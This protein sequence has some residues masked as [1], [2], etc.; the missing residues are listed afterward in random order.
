MPTMWVRADGELELREVPR[1]E[2]TADRVLVRTLVSAV[3]GSDLHRFRGALSYGRDTDVFGHE[4]VVEVIAGG[5]GTLVPGQRMLHLPFPEEGK[6]FA[7]Y[8]LA[9]EGNLIPLPAGLP[10]GDAVLAQQLGTVLHA[11][12]QFWP[13]PT[14]PRSAFIAGAGPAGLLFVQVLRMLGC[15]QIAVSEPHPPRLA[16]AQR[17][18]AVTPESVP[19]ANLSIDAVGELPARRDCF[20]HTRRA[21]TLGAFGLPDREPGELGI[22]LLEL[23]GRELRLV[24]AQGA[25]SEPGLGSFHRAIDLLHRRAIDTNCLISHRI[26]LPE[27]PQACLQAAGPS[28]DIVKVLVVFS[29]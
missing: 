4:S 9:R 18:G 21:G 5:S 17:L 19:S 2:P 11:L 8:Q 27:L 13:W 14:P 20:A 3:C 12:D 10:D 7:D 26:S 15:A 22:S 6:V 23:L 29:S 28:G 1:P 24:G 25:Q 16:L